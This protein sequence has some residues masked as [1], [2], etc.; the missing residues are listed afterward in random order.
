MFE[1]LFV[2]KRDSSQNIVFIKISW[3]TCLQNNIWG[4]FLS[5]EIT[6]SV[7]CILDMA[8]LTFIV[9]VNSLI[10]QTH[11]IIWGDVVTTGDVLDGLHENKYECNIL[12]YFS[13]QLS[14]IYILYLVT[15]ST[16]HC[17]KYIS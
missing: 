7:Y 3:T 15:Y 1:E 9:D 14:I 12:W 17:K 11:N 6:R 2:A 13:Q 8:V 16:K 10:D 5:S 4:G